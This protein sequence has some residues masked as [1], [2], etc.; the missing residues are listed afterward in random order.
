V[1]YNLSM[2][3]K[4]AHKTIYG[5]YLTVFGAVVT[6]A[7]NVIFVP[8]YGY[9]ASAW[10]TLICYAST[11]VLSYFIS[12]K[13]FPVKFEML[14]IGLYFA[15]SLTLY[16]VSRQISFES[17]AMELIVNNSLTLLFA[18]VVFFI[19]KPSFSLLKK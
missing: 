3:Y 12:M 19:E 10:A 15:I 1:F 7:I 8:R 14:R 5:A 17:K 9:M 6:V 11:M 16:F 18:L 2:W 4:L 13:H